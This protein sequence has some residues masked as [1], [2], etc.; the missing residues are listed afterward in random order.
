MLAGCVL[1][2]CVLAGCV[3]A[4]CVVLKVAVELVVGVALVVGVVVDDVPVGVVEVFV[5]VAV[6]VDWLVDVLSVVLVGVDLVV[7]VTVR[8]V[9]VIVSMV[10]E[11]PKKVVG[12]PLPVIECPVRSSGTVNAPTTMA[13]ASSPVATAG[14]QLRRPRE[15]PLRCA[16]MP[17]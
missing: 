6:V 4:G 1:A 5:R 11:P 16:F 13:N 17:E 2:G 12:R 10:D 15:T 9:V 3:L 7:T 14:R 8:L